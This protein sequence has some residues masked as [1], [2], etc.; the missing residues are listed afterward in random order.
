[1]NWLVY[2]PRASSKCG[3]RGDDASAFCSGQ[4]AIASNSYEYSDTTG[5]KTDRTAVF[6]RAPQCPSVFAKAQL[7]RPFLTVS[8]CQCSLPQVPLKA[9][10]TSSNLVRA[11]KTSQALRGL[12]S[13]LVRLSR[14]QGVPPVRDPRARSASHS[15]GSLMVMLP[16]SALQS[17]AKTQMCAP[18]V[19]WPM[20]VLRALVSSM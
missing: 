13:Y 2:Q 10:I 12:F 3:L 6:P 5:S 20:R 18:P 9:E 15:S 11:T 8:H 16:N 7:R 4:L 17:S 14:A 1:M 19:E